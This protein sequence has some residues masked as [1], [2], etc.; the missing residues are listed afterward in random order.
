MWPPSEMLAIFVAFLLGEALAPYFVQRFLATRT[1]SDT[2]T[3]VTLFGGYYG[4]YTLVVIAL[5]LSGIVLLHGTEPDLVLTSLVRDVVPIG[6]KGAVFAALLAAVMST[7]D[8]ILN[9]AS[10]VLTRDLYQK[11]WRPEASDRAMLRV[12]RVSTLVIGIGGVVAALSLPDVFALLVYTYTLWAPSIIP[13]LIVAL[14]WGAPRERRVAPKAA[15]IAIVTG[16][17]TTF[18]WE[19]LGSP[20]RLPPVVVGVC[21]NLAALVVSHRYLTASAPGRWFTPEDVPEEHAV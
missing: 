16:L 7:G 21:S 20:L 18:V 13:P 9:N 4:F 12:A 15:A 3:G 10:V 19:R 1:P 8:S 2:R 17:V 14:L 11:L 5:G 6:L